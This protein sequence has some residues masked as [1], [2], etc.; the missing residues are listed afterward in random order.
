M[1]RKSLLIT[2]II[3]LTWHASAQTDFW[4]YDPSIGE[5]NTP[6][7]QNSVSPAQPAAINTLCDGGMSS[8]S[9]VS[10]I[11]ASLWVKMVEGPARNG[12]VVIN[13]CVLLLVL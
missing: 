9:A 7:A 4:Y 6:A 11:T 5:V 2:T 8:M 13:R 3:F 12:M 10:C 1:L